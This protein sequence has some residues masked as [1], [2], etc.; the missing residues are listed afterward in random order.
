MIRT[1]GHAI[2]YPSNTVLKDVILRS[3]PATADSFS[4]FDGLNDVV[5]QQFSGTQMD[6]FHISQFIDFISGREFD[7]TK[8]TVKKQSG[9]LIEKTS[10]NAGFDTIE[11][12]YSD[13]LGNVHMSMYVEW[14][15]VS[16]K[17]DAD[18]P[19]R[20][21]KVFNTNTLRDKDGEESIEEKY[22]L[23]RKSDTDISASERA[24]II[25]K[26][27][28]LIKSIWSHS[29]DKQA[30][31]FSF[32]FGIWNK[33]KAKNGNISKYDFQK[34]LTI[35]IKK[36]GRFERYFSHA[37]D[38]KY[39][40]YPAACDI[41][42]YSADH[43]VEFNLLVSYAR[44]LEKLGIDV[45]KED[46]S[47]YTNDFVNSIIC[48]YLPSNKEY[49]TEYGKLDIEVAAAINPENILS[50]VKM[51]LYNP[52]VDISKSNYI[53]YTEAAYFA[54]QRF[55]IAAM[56]GDVPYDVLEPNETAYKS[57]LN[58]VAVKLTDGAL[59]T[60]PAKL[61]EGSDGLIYSDSDGE[62]TILTSNIDIFVSY[63][64]NCVAVMFTVSGMVVTIDEETQ[65]VYYLT[66]ENAM[67]FLN[68][69]QDKNANWGAV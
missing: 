41:F 67:R 15:C 44:C 11:D 35:K 16:F 56:A 52:N 58:T 50:K 24:E 10:I 8:V 54:S 20:A 66:Y 59:K 45:A 55:I 25:T 37:D 49:F 17:K 36:D 2:P 21:L 32:L 38:N 12:V 34:A 29:K 42:I 14:L 5:L 7:P 27:P 53:D 68:G 65:D 51:D 30:N 46:A 64:R 61:V 48:T 26:L 4:P 3:G 31:L 33:L 62:V 23:E 22:L 28:Y 18:S 9:G 63:P 13:P 6:N 43:P 40:I 39:T 1:L 19:Y 60:F 47:I 57:L 69:E